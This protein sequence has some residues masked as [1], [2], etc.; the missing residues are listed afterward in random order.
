MYKMSA[1]INILLLFYAHVEC[2]TSLASFVN[3]V[4][5]L[6]LYISYY[7]P[8]KQIKIFSFFYVI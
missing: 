3:D 5:F 4:E 7:P 2:T 6:G 1:K 8:E